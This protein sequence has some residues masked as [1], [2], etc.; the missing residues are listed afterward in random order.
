MKN[1]FIVLLTDNFGEDVLIKL[2][3]NIVYQN[4]GYIPK[5]IDSNMPPS[6]VLINA[7]IWGNTSEGFDYWNSIHKILEEMEEESC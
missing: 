4:P 7:F 5:V 3:T 1:D 6:E 2:F